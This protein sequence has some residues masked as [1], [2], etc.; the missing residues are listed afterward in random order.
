MQTS[1]D[2][3]KGSRRYRRS[4]AGILASAALV[5]L[6]AA[7]ASASHVSGSGV[8]EGA[9]TI[10]GQGVQQTPPCALIDSV[11]VAKVDE[12]TWMVNGAT[13]TGP[14]AVM[15]NVPSHYANPQ[16]THSSLATCDTTPEAIPGTKATITSGYT[17]NPALPGISCA[18]LNGTF[19]RSGTNVTF[20]LAGSCTVYSGSG[21]A[22]TSNVTLT[23]T[24][25]FLGCPPFAGPVK[26]TYAC[27]YAAGQYT[28]SD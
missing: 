22:Q 8:G 28:L 19:I 17:A 25:Q 5:M 3:K 26:V 4:L 1:H 10:T 6:S 27:A 12:G 14:A 16:G 24:G 7:P 2:K 13:Y 21:T 11:T 23:Q 9:V 15:I 18:S 20:T